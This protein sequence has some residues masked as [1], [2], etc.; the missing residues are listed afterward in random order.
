MT[1]TQNIVADDGIVEFDDSDGKLCKECQVVKNR[2][3]FH[4]HPT[5]RDRLY[6]ICKECWNKKGRERYAERRIVSERNLD[7]AHKFVHGYFEVAEL[8][9]EE[10][11]G[12]Y[13]LNDDGTKVSVNTLAEKFRSKFSRELGRRINDYLR[14]KAPRAVE[15]MFQLADSDFVEPGDRIKAATWIAERVIGKTPE[16]L[17]LGNADKP[18]EA[19]FESSIE[20]STREAF[21]SASIID[22]EVVSIENGT[23]S[24]TGEANE[25]GQ[26][27]EDI[28]DRK[29]SIKDTKDRIR[30]AKSRRFAARAAG[31]DCV[32]NAPWFVRIV[33]RKDGTFTAYLTEPE[34]ITEAKL[35][36]IR[37]T[38]G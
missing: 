25:D 4:A 31:V 32:D 19:I 2:S 33:K 36:N 29:Q 3:E 22:V 16:V 18:Y 38:A 37:K 17:M 5:N 8:S 7:R 27:T 21:R 15:I 10:V 23:T 11:F 13:V 12:S 9:D 6:H 30:K 24:K 34:E 20:T 35:A 14:R 1:V 26:T 28:E